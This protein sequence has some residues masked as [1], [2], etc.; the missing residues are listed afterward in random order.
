M[1]PFLMDAVRVNQVPSGSYVNINLLKFMVQQ[2]M[3]KHI[4]CT[5]LKILSKIFRI[6]H[7]RLMG[8]YKK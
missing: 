7:K 2:C 4:F 6:A 1:Y 3:I 5:L 8:Q